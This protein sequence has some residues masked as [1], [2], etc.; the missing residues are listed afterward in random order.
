MNYGKLIEVLNVYVSVVINNTTREYDKFYDYIVPDELCDYIMP[1]VRVLV[2]F[3]RGNRLREAF[4]M[5]VKQTSQF[6]NLKEVSQVIDDTPIL[7]SELIG[8][9]KYMKKRY[10][11]TYDMAIHCMLPTGLGLLYRQ[12]AIVVNDSFTD[13]NISELNEDEKKIIKMLT[14]NDGK[15]SVDKLKEMSKK[16]VMKVLNELVLKEYIQIVNHFEMKIKAKTVKAAYPI[17]EEEEFQELINNNKIR[18]INYIRIMEMLFEERLI[19]VSEL[20]ALGYSTAV[21]KNMEKRG[22]ISMLD[23][24]VERDP[25]EDLDIAQTKPLPPTIG[26]EKALKTI[27]EALQSKQYYEILLHGVTS[28]GKTEVY[29]QAIGQAI[30]DG[31]NAI[32]LVPEIGLTPQTVRQ[33]KGR[34]GERVAVLHSRLSMGERYD[35]WNKIRNGDVR[36]VI[37]ARSAI[38]APLEN[39][40]IIIIDEEHETSYKSDRTP[41]YDVRG[42]AAYRCMFNNATLLYGSATPSIENYYRAITGKIKLVEMNERTNNKP[43]PD[44]ITV[45]MRR[46]Q[47]KGLRNEFSDLLVQEL[48]KNKELGEQ[49]LIFINRRGYSNFILCKECGYI[50][51]CP[52]CSVSL[53]YHQ[54]VQRLV[55]HYCSYTTVTPSI[56]PVCKN[57]HIEP[58]GFGTQKVEEHIP[59]ICKDMSVIRMDLDT[60]S[61]KHGHQTILD[62]FKND[63]IDVMV[64]T[65]MIA[66]GHDFPNVTL[67]GI[68][69][70]DSLLGSGDFRASERTFQLITQSA[71]RA[72][73]AEKK[74]RVILQTYDPDNFSIKSAINQ[75]YKDF[76]TQ[77]IA[78]RNALKLPPFYQL[79]L[80]QVSAKDKE[81]AS[82]IINKIHLDIINN[83]TMDSDIFVSTPAPSPISKLKNQYRWRIVLKHPKIKVLANIFEWIYD[84]YSGSGKRQ[85][86][87]SM[88]IN[89]YSMI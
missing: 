40:G 89:P 83:I 18:S 77:E 28:S 32:M 25:L 51:L 14:E 5:E 60:T 88:D 74:G 70:A 48:I 71:G 59:L 55:C 17:K 20:N 8:L 53:T 9:S 3:G 10:I 30:K 49:S 11:C 12:D 42:I 33:F 22:Y 26:Q 76:Y 69:S 44:I 73:R 72:G 16:P 38:F 35:Q 1:G 34:F 45:D 68:L 84:K 29:M 4:V 13:Q 64:G 82:N 57:E 43:L 52:Y 61:S 2:P 27:Y 62:T 39:I 50:V 23:I 67:V 7:T 87:V 80:V 86:T 85:W 79:G 21:L 19:F 41:K 75:D 6:A 54:A 65:Q 63:Q 66:K 46:E 47:D 56:C 15:L 81:M 78:L 37:G 36:V 24:Q 58:Y 31:R